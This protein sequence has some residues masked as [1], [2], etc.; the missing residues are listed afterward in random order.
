MVEYYAGIGSRKTPY[1]VLEMMK[2]VAIYLEDVGYILRS[3]GA[4][5]ADSAFESGVVR[6]NK[7]IFYANDV[8]DDSPALELASRIHP[9]WERC[10]PYVRK[11]MAR[12]CWQILGKDLKTPVHGII[13]WTEGG[14][15]IGGT[16]QALR[17]AQMHDI[18]I[19]NLGC[20]P[21]ENTIQSIR[22][23]FTNTL[24]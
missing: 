20:G 22:D 9:A 10:K 11:L 24:D 5:G 12:N 13:C 23:W 1:H 15:M 14:R 21:Y 8:P 16:S 17:L 6:G 18:S 2:R 7:E 3:G 19:F 4:E